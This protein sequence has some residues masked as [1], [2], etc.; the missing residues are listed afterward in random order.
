M[1]GVGRSIVDSDR[2][3]LR[4]SDKDGGDGL[5]DIGIVPGR[6]SVRIYHV[7]KAY[8]RGQSR[9]SNGNGSQANRAGEYGQELRTHLG[10]VRYDCG[11]QQCMFVVKTVEVCRP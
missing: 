11:I 1:D 5:A 9:C 8:L 2:D 3:W 4:D 10:V 7:R 6:W